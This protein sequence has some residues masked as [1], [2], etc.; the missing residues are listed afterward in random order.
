M[1]K[2]FRILGLIAILSAIVLGAQVYIRYQQYGHRTLAGITFYQEQNPEL[3]VHIMADS[4]MNTGGFTDWSEELLQSDRHS[5][6]HEEPLWLILPYT[7]DTGMW[8]LSIVRGLELRIN[9]TTYQNGDAITGLTDHATYEISICEAWSGETLESGS[10]TVRY[11][12]DVPVLFAET[13]D[14][15][16]YDAIRETKYI[17]AAVDWFCLDANGNYDSSGN[18]TMSGHGNSSYGHSSKKPVNLRLNEAQS[19]LEIGA[20]E[21]YV[22]IANSMD[23]SNLK[24]M[25]VYE[26]ARRMGM[27]YTPECAYV[28]YYVNGEYEGLYLLSQKIDLTRG[29]IQ[30]EKDLDEDTKEIHGGAEPEFTDAVDTQNADYLF[31]YNAKGVTPD[32]YSGAYLL[33]LQY[34]GFLS[35]KVNNS[36]YST[37]H[38]GLWFETDTLEMLIRSPKYASK[39]EVAYI[40]NIVLEAE[41]ALYASDG[42]NPR[43]GKS[44]EDYFDATSWGQLIL[45]ED[46]FSMQDYSLGS[47]F[48]LKK[49]GDDLLYAGPIWDYDKAMC[50]DYYHREEYQFSPY[51]QAGLGFWMY[52]FSAKDKIRD[53]MRNQYVRS[54]SEIMKE[55]NE[56][57]IPQWMTRIESA[58]ATDNLR[59]GYDEDYAATWA[60]RV[61]DWCVKRTAYFD[62]VWISKDMDEA[63]ANV[64][65]K[66]VDVHGNDV[67]K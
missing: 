49:Q 46:F 67:E 10:V 2:F 14:T 32:D 63:N 43:N 26:A 38:W 33:E 44:Y 66:E 7:E 9:E 29:C 36:A 39:T 6:R 56:A 34:P 1:K 37:K 24:D 59:W 61:Q 27:E 35:S 64:W 16:A 11:N 3:Y 31:G 42:K 23:V 8:R 51:D 13:D 57:D 19:I 18:A 17:D 25:I 45:L 48:V 21:K 41:D 47:I 22:L 15:D 4:E 30:G 62:S 20:V 52:Q 58:A 5:V 40:R 55:L 65:P 50:D 54:L 12:G 53:E 28:V 60:K